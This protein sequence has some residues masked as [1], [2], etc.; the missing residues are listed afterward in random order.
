MRFC[1]RI[2]QPQFNRST[3]QSLRNGTKQRTSGYVSVSPAHTTPLGLSPSSIARKMALPDTTPQCHS[4]QRATGPFLLTEDLSHSLC[5]HLQLH[6]AELKLLVTFV[7]HSRDQLS[8]QLTRLT[9]A[10]P[11]FNVLMFH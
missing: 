1:V 11:S 8:D 2:H 7:L 3:K 6:Q 4:L 9:Q 10:T 5:Q